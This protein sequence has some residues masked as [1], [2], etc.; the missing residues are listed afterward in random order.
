MGSRPADSAAA[1]PG[2]RSSRNK[3]G[4]RDDVIEATNSD[5]LSSIPT[6][7]RRQWAVNK[8]PPATKTMATQTD[9]PVE[10]ATQTPTS[11]DEGVQTVEMSEK[12]VQPIAEIETQ[13]SA[14]S[15]DQQAEEQFFITTL[16]EIVG[17][18]M[19]QADIATESK[20]WKEAIE[21]F[22]YVNVIMEERGYPVKMAPRRST[23]QQDTMRESSYRGRGSGARGSAVG[24]QF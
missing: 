24:M 11:R 7:V 21:K 20:F 14:K 13:T 18:L 16:L 3:C 23:R 6:A 12:A 22:N 19:D 4:R 15:E 17:K 8:K 10:Q 9:E 2:N 1:P 5:R